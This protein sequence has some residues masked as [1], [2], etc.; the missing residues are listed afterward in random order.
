MTVNDKN[1]FNDIDAS[2]RVPLLALFGGAAVWLIAGLALALIASIKFHAPEF[3][4]GCPCL[5]YGRV[6]AASND[7]LLY[8][9]TIPAILGVTLWVFVRLSQAPLCVPLASVIAANLWHVGVLIGTIAILIGETTGQNWLEYGRGAAPLLFFAFLLIAISAYATYGS[10]AERTLYPSHWFLLA[11]LLWFPWIY[12][13][14]NLLL[15]GFPVRGVV[16]AIVSWWFANNLIYVWLALSGI[17][18]IFY[19]IPKISGK[20]L[21][22]SYYAQFAF[23]TLILF[24]TWCGIPQGAPVPKWMPTLSSVAAALTIIPVATIGLIG[25]K[26]S[27]CGG[28]PKA[29]PFCFAR[30]G[31][32]SFLASSLMMIVSSCP[33]FS[34]V[35]GFT[36]FGVA[37]SHLQ[38][39]GFGTMVAL[40]GI[41]YLMPRVMGFELPFPKLAKAHFW[42]SVLGVVL[43][44]VPL[45]VAGVMQGRTNF[46][47]TA[48]KMWLQISTTGL[49]LLLLGSL[50]FAANIFAMTLKWKMALL[51]TGFKAVTAPLKTSE[52]KS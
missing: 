3:L 30:F 31:L 7:L 9:F 50:L 21:Y 46:D 40:G 49:L 2:C 33:K 16:Q 23:W 48:G 32:V 13:T 18:I 25:F 37:Q 27:C 35:V 45:A 6:I 11:S 20:P 26:T 39:L 4:A 28:M 12:S 51:K 41:Y 34:H 19:L 24:A 5:T 38:I 29:G 10:R 47:L 1:N 52:V 43:Y 17:G 44:I 36:W 42:L 14:A 8:G 22:S 15:I